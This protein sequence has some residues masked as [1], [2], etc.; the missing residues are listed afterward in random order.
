[1]GNQYRL[2]GSATI[3]TGDTDSFDICKVLKLIV[4][5]GHEFHVEPKKAEDGYTA[6]I[7]IELEDE[8]SLKLLQDLKRLPYFQ[9]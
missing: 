6:K 3:T 8:Q 2:Q 1:M 5:A 4:E 7:T 9:A